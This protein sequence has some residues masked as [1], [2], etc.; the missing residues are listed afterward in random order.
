MEE[1]IYIS[2]MSGLP[3]VVTPLVLGDV[4]FPTF[5]EL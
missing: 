2:P 5:A 4:T 1:K 3:A